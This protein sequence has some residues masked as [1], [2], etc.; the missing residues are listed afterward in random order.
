LL[1]AKTF[2]VQLLSVVKKFRPI[3]NWKIIK[4]FSQD[5]NPC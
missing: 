3:K 4:V 2:E 1:I 5:A